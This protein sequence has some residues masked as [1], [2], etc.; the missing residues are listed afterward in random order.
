M[1]VTESFGQD[2]RTALR[3]LAKNP[4]ATALSILSIGLGIGLTTGTFSITDA[5]LLRPFPLERPREVMYATS[6]GDDGRNVPYGWPDYEDMLQAG[7]GLGDLAAYQRRGTTLAVG[8]DTEM[9]ITHAVTPN[10]FSLLGVKA[11]LGRASVGESEGLPGVVLGYRLW[12]RRF[13]GDPRMVGQTFLISRKAFLVTGVMPAEFTGLVRGV[14]TDTWVGMEAWFEVLGR[15]SERQERKGQFEIVARLKPGANAERVAAQLDAAIRG[16][17]KHNPAA[18]GAPG[19]LLRARFAPG[20]KDSLVFG[21]GM[22]LMLGLVL[23]VACANV[24]QLRLAQAESR[25]REFGIRLALGAGAWRLTRQLL[26]ETGVVSVAGVGLG[27]LLARFVMDTASRFL[28]AGR[29]YIDYGIGLDHRVLAFTLAAGLVS[30]LLAGLAPARHAVR[31]DLAEVVKSEQGVTGARGGWQKK[32]LIVGQIAVSVALFGTAVLFLASLRNAMAVRPGFDPAKQ[33]LVL[34]VGPGWERSQT[35]PWCEQAAER[36]SGLPGVR[37]ATFARRLPLSGSGGGATV[38]V[39]IPG[40]E[41]LGIRFNNVGGNYFPVMGTRVMAGRGIDASDRQG[42]G[43]AVVV[44]G[45]FVRRAFPDR[46]PVGQWILIGGEL[47]QVVGVA[48]DGPSN[49]LHEE[50]EP[51]LYFPFAQKPSGDITLMVETAGEP[52]ALSQAVRQELKRF[53][54][55]VTVG[56]ITT[57]DR[58]MDQALSGDRMMAGLAAGL[59]LVGLLLTAAGLFGVIQ[60][61][62]N[63]RTR[64]FGLRSALGAE[65]A[66]IRRMVLVDSARMAGWGISIGLAL[67]AASARYFRSMAL[68]VSPLDPSLYLASAMAVVTVAFAAA[69][70]PAHRATRVDPMTALRHE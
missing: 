25:R 51:F 67:L 63:R 21:G 56:S 5:M 42:S 61:T 59:G 19:T 64:E 69:W 40:Q 66:A 22:L 37:G 10:Y 54:P 49:N 34:S 53:D 28:S 12:Q 20:W 33:L 11:A 1:S 3:V 68:G 23:F 44:S 4:G 55:R 14:A 60:Y 6:R 24:A 9:L 70:F 32:A 57:L 50:S 36:L 48:E 43:L 29:V 52:A 17:G 46:N 35:V 31:V 58:H 62:A 13:G 41:P 7:K 47:R 39:E 16:P 30:I 18:A 45:G 15:R 8:E 27:L 65:P 2:F 26:V 38:R